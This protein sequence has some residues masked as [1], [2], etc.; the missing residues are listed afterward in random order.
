M[1]PRRTRRSTS[2]TAKKPAKSLVNPWVSRMNSSAN[3]I[4][5][6]SHRREVGFAGLKFPDRQVLPSYL[7]NPVPDRP[8]PNANMP[9][10]ARFTQGGKL[11]IRRGRHG[12]GFAISRIAEACDGGVSPDVFGGRFKRGGKQPL[13]VFR[14]SPSFSSKICA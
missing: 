2:R 12:R 7:G 4:P 1:L 6:V 9:L 5:P 14:C 10:T 11:G 3:Q 8:P 13:T